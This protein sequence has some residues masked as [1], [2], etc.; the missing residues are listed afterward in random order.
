MGILG[1]GNRLGLLL[2]APG[3]AEAW[4][5]QPR[6]PAPK[7][8]GSPNSLHPQRPPALDTFCPEPPGC[9]GSLPLPPAG[10]LGSLSSPAPLPRCPGSLEP[11]PPWLLGFPTPMGSR[12]CMFRLPGVPLDT[13]VLQA[14]PNPLPDDW[15]PQASPHRQCTCPAKV[16]RGSGHP[17]QLP[18]HVAFPMSPSPTL[19]QKHSSTGCP[20]FPQQV[21]RP[22]QLSQHRARDSLRPAGTASLPPMALS[23]EFPTSCWEQPDPEDRVGATPP[24]RV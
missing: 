1:R 13:W 7:H 22:T 11:T 18:P 15:G 8:L 24:P 23:L 5:P 16:L 9:L 14:L 12:P 3:P 17:L 4:L 20:P 6:P 19:G 10:C 2:L 21:A